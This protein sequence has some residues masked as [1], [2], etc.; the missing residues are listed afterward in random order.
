MKADIL[1]DGKRN[2]DHGTIMESGDRYS[3][4]GQ[5]CENGDFLDDEGMLICS[6]REFVS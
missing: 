5:F 3:K 1:P 2:D 6:L 4:N